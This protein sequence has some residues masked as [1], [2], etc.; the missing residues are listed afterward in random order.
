MV[1]PEALHTLNILISIKGFKE[2]GCEYQPSKQTIGWC[3]PNDVHDVM[4]IGFIKQVKQ[5]LLDFLGI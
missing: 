4:L 1:V 2:V 5:T 3:N